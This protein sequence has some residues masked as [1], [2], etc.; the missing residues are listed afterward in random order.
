MDFKSPYL[1]Q[2]IIAYIGNK[3]KLLPLVVK[4][5]KSTGLR[6]EPGL[7]FFDVFS[8]SGSVSRLAKTLQFEV[9]TNDW[10]E[11]A[12]ILNK[13]FV[14][15]DKKKLETLFC[16][17]QNV[18]S[19][20]SKINA[21]KAPAESRQYIAKYYAPKSFDTAKAD[22]KT[23]RLFYS[24]ENALAIDKIRNYIERHFP[25]NA[26]ADTVQKR[27]ILLAQLIY[28]AATHTNTSGVFKAY[29]KGFGGHRQDALGRILKLIQLHEPV[30]IDSAFP[31]HVYKQDANILVQDKSLPRMDIAYLDPPYNQHQYGSNYHLLNTIARWD[32]IPE[33]LE[34]NEMGE[35]KDKAAIRHD[36]INTKSPYCYKNEAE[37]A[38]RDLIEHLNAHYILISYSTDGIIPFE[39]MKDICMNKGRLSIVTNEYTTYRGGKQSNKRTNTNIEFILCID[40]EK[41]SDTESL[42]EIDTMLARKKTMLLFKQKFS[43]SK[44]CE[45]LLVTKDK[46]LSIN[47]SGKSIFLETDNYFD[48]NPPANIDTLTIEELKQLQAILSRCVCSTKEEELKEL[49][50]KVNSDEASCKLLKLIPKT[51]KKLASKKNKDRFF[52]WIEKIELLKVSRPDS[53]Q[54]IETEIE[55]IKLLGQERFSS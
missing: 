55:D 38:F 46:S 40:T 14:E 18:S 1:T 28:E 10:E 17:Q 47:L 50:D 20:I 21:L 13:G 53:Y 39:R 30:L 49:L 35:L 25:A 6:I 26:D 4:A 3:R 8:G 52:Y 2:Q 23:E 32:H 15:T 19:L 22:F 5:V 11:Y 48:V 12:Y 41:T 34:L 27:H 9:Y 45:N 54:E 43:K 42:Q 37:A 51:V 16:G 7:K 44:L 29:H 36:W 24:R 31:V 33:P